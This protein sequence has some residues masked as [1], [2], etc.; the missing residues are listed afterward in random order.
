MRAT[1]DGIDVLNVAFDVTPSRYV[2]AIVTESGVVRAPY[3]EGLR[4]IAEAPVD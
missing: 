1:P 4:R 2:T 3:D